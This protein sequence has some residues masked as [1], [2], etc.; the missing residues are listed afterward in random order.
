M[1]IKSIKVT[2]TAGVA[3]M[4]GK[5]EAAMI[6]QPIKDMVAAK[7]KDVPDEQLDAAMAKFNFPEFLRPAI[8]QLVKEIRNKGGEKILPEQPKALPGAAKQLNPAKPMPQLDQI[9]GSTKKT[10]K[11]SKSQWEDIGKKTGWI[12]S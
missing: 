11:I 6:P 4:W 5:S 3:E 9:E 7:L 2:K 8:R 12:K 1:N 10:I